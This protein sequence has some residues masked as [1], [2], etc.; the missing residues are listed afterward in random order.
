MLLPARAS[1]LEARLELLV[2]RALHV[3][4]GPEPLDELL[5]LDGHVLDELLGL[6]GAARLLLDLARVLL[7]ALALLLEARLLLPPSRLVA[8]APRLLV[9]QLVPALA[10]PP[11]LISPSELAGSPRQRS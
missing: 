7:L 10:A 1:Q 3:L 8:L 11:R 5:L 2:G 6:D 4:R 9:A